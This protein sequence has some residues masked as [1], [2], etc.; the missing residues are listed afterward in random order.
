MQLIILRAS[1]PPAV[2]PSRAF[3]SCFL[4]PGVFYFAV[5]VN[6]PSQL[7]ADRKSDRDEGGEERSEAGAHQRQ[8]NADHRQKPELHT[9][10][11][12]DL[13]SQSA[14]DSHDY[15]HTHAIGRSP[16]SRNQPRQQN[17]IGK[18]DENTANEASVAGGDGENEIRVWLREKLETAL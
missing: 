1:R 4:L 8:R 13:A 10:V 6:K 16:R 9:D 3:C 2:F 17:C 12:K 11:D 18:Q 5:S 15:Q 14:N 7:H